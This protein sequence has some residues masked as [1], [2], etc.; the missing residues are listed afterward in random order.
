M[1]YLQLNTITLRKFAQTGI[2]A[3][4]PKLACDAG[5]CRT[6]LNSNNTNFLFGCALIA[7]II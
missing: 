1:F 4:G 7:V 6:V 5:Q 2:V 3:T